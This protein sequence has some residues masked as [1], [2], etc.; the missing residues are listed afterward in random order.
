MGR[1]QKSGDEVVIIPESRWTYPMLARHLKVSVRTLKR[2]VV[3]GMVPQPTILNNRGY[4]SGAALV[5]ARSGLQLPGTFD[6][7][8]NPRE[9]K[10]ADTIEYRQRMAERGRRLRAARAARL[11]R[12]GKVTS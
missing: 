4:W 10:R 9:Q 5:A 6:Y 8:P 7:T 3:N 12:E 2:Y 11:K 1:K